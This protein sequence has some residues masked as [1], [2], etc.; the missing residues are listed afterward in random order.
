MPSLFLFFF[1]A[2]Y[3]TNLLSAPSSLS[4][5]FFCLQTLREYLLSVRGNDHNALIKGAPNDEGISTLIFLGFYINN[6]THPYTKYTQPYTNYTLSI[7][8]LFL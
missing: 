5:F 2:F 8:I 1:P 4:Y 3:R 6:Y 7:M